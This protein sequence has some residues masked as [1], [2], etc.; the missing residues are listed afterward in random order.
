VQGDKLARSRVEGL[1]DIF[2]FDD[3]FQAIFLTL[4]ST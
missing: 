4:S 1:A 2:D 3:G